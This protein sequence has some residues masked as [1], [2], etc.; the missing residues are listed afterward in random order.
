MQRVA[1]FFFVFFLIMRITFRGTETKSQEKHN[2]GAQV[3][4]TFVKV[5]IYNIYESTLYLKFRACGF[6]FRQADAFPFSLP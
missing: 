3:K 4:H 1:C 6:V 2:M 5:N